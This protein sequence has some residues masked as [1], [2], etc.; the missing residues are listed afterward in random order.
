MFSSFV[1]HDHAAHRQSFA[2]FILSSILLL[3][4]CTWANAEPYR[5][6]RRQERPALT[7]RCRARI[8]TAR[9]TI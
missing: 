2:R 4:R 9:A 6:K 8:P 7:A 3:L 5:V 1:K